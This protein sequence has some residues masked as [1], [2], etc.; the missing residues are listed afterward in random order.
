MRYVARQFAVSV[1]FSWPT[2]APFCLTLTV[3]VHLPAIITCPVPVYLSAPEG[4]SFTSLRIAG[5]FIAGIA[6]MTS[7]TDTS[8][9]VTGFPA[10]SLTVT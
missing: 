5:M 2:S 9:S 4:F 10:A 8:A 3:T 1:S 7:R 6:G